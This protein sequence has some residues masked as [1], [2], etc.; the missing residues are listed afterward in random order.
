MLRIGGA[1]HEARRHLGGDVDHRQVGAVDAHPLLHR[2]AGARRAVEQPANHLGVEAGQHRAG[3]RH[4]GRPVRA[5]DDVEHSLAGVVAPRD[6][7]LVLARHRQV[8]AVARGGVARDAGARAA[9]APHRVRRDTLP[10]LTLREVQADLRVRARLRERAVGRRLIIGRRLP[11]HALEH[12]LDGAVVQADSDQRHRSHVRVHRPGAVARRAH[13]APEQHV[14]GGMLAVRREPERRNRP[15]RGPQH[16]PIRAPG[17]RHEVEL[18]GAARADALSDASPLLTRQGQRALRSLPLQ[19]AGAVHR[20]E[21]QAERVGPV[22]VLPGDPQLRSHERHH[23]AVPRAEQAEIDRGVRPPLS[24][25][26]RRLLRTCQAAA[27]RRRLLR[28][29]RS[30]HHQGHDDQAAFHDSPSG[31][32]AQRKPMSLRT[33]SFSKLREVV[34]ALCLLKR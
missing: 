11:R 27:R 10:A 30:H 33:A 1:G 17:A 22:A 15:G 31:S 32:M 28:G 2:E 26:Q 21:P 7:H 19:Q 18:Q 34:R 4:D 12:L 14:P 20:G 29:A 16:G 8:G 23:R 24:A 13:L 9:L 5:A 3:Q 25:R 6:E